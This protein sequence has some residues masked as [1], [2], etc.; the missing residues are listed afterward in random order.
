[1]QQKWIAILDFGSHY[2]QLLAQRIRA[3]QVYSE[4]LRCDTAA[5]VLRERKPAGIILSGGAN[6][7]SAK[8]ALACDPAVFE[9]GVPILGISYGMQLMTKMLG[10]TVTPGTE[11]EYGFSR[12]VAVQGARLLTGNTLDFDVWMSLGDR[13]DA[14]PPGFAVSARSLECP[15]AAMRDE[16]RNF[17]ALQFHPEATY[18]QNGDKILRNFVSSVCGCVGNWQLAAWA[19]AAV[20]SLKQK[21]GDERVLLGLSG[22][23]DSVVASVLLHKAIGDRLQCIFVDNGLLRFNEVKQVEER[24]RAKLGIN[25]HTVPAAERFYAALKGVTDPEQKRQIIRREFSAVFAEEAQKFGNSKFLAQGTIYS[26]IADGVCL[27]KDPAEV[28][29]AIGLPDE[30]KMNFELIE[31]LRDL[32]KDEVRAVG[33]VLGIDDELIDRQ[34]F[35]WPGLAIRISGE[36]TAENVQ[37]LQ[38]ADIR[39]KEEMRKLSTY[40]NIWKCFAI[41]LPVT[42][43]GIRDYKRT[44]GRVCVVRCVDNAD[45]RAVDWTRV[46]NDTLNRISNRIVNE[47]PGIN[48]VLFDITSKPPATVEWE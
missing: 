19:D 45:G 5:E 4:I 31:P 40:K 47:V 41:L 35:S 15:I 43:L 14:L 1:M 12:V 36:V 37:L 28:V 42:S 38:Q 33:R 23:V 7:V 29:H 20:E 44:Y 3:Q 26:D 11:G 13:V 46:P 30:V 6:S 9:L 34:P 25:V 48:R 27:T 17:Y 16:A 10:G 22:G 24:L 39:V 32:F 2:T 21:I 8:D 18:T